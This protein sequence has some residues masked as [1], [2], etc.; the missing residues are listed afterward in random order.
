[1]CT[2]SYIPTS[3]GYYFTSSRD[4]RISRTT[5]PPVKYSVNGID[6]YFPKDELAGGTW[7][8]TN[9]SGKTACLLNGAFSNHTKEKSYKK[10]RGLVLL[11]S[12]NFKN[13]TDFANGTDFNQVEPFTLLIIDFSISQ[14]KHFDEFRWDGKNKHL[15]SLPLTEIQLWSSATLY[16]QQ[17]QELRRSLFDNWIEKH[18]HFED[19]M[20]LDFHNRKHGL[21]PTDDILMQGYKNLRTLS[22]SQIHVKGNNC[23]FKYV[24][25]VKNKTQIIRSKE[26]EIVTV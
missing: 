23:N 13:I 25:I 19:K 26:N 9:L 22:I 18:K 20:I 8:A 24:D 12:F 10:S 4:E 3:D 15:K 11:E 17:V 2:V 14:I 16:P 21:N 6:L 5:I 1:M 7:I